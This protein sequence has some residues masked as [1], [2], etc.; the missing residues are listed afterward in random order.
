MK[1]IIINFK[2]VKI[3]FPK[4]MGESLKIPCQVNF[5]VS[6]LVA[7]SKRE[8]SRHLI[9]GKKSQQYLHPK[10]TLRRVV[11]SKISVIRN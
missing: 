6:C 9:F 1:K 3:C 7:W 8:K 4:K 10:M 11:I 2:Y 5:F